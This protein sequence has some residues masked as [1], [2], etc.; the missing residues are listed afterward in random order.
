MSNLLQ[1]LLQLS[2]VELKQQMVQLSE[3]EK[4]L[5]SEK[6]NKMTIKSET[7][8]RIGIVE[9]TTK[10]TSIYVSLELDTEAKNIKIDTGIGFLN[11]MLHTLSKFLSMDLQ[12]QCKGDLE[13]D[14]HHTVEDVALAIGNAFDKALGQRIGIQRFGHAYA[15]LDEALAR[16]VVDI[17]SRPS[18]S[19]DL[20]LVREKVGEL[21][22]EMA[23][24]WFHSFAIA[25]RLTCHID[26]LKGSNDHHKIEASF[27]ALALALK[28]AIT[29]DI[30]SKSS[31]PSTKGVLF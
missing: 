16:A 17:S 2:E 28:E 13:V 29:I 15:P 4:I 25:S 21:S 30:S 22:T 1:S 31:I 24:H 7:S 26:V 20:Q 11:H 23:S 27:K 3:Q 18:S 5:L 6:L 19:I 10:E 9:R 14:D 8:K 12:V